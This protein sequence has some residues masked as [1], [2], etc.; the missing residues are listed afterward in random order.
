ME[1]IK[2]VENH[3]ISKLRETLMDIK[4]QITPLVPVDEYINVVEDEYTNVVEDEKPKQTGMLKPGVEYDIDP[5]HKLPEHVREAVRE[6]LM[7]GELTS[8]EIAMQERIKNMSNK[9]KFKLGILPR[10][11]KA[12][13]TK[14]TIEKRTSDR[15]KKNKVARASRKANR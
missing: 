1:D 7:S 14:P 8:D 4:S 9:K 10:G 3:S 13:F 5:E 6:K 12:G 2:D 11:Y 15:R